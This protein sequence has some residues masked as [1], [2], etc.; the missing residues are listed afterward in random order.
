[1]LKTT[2]L[3]SSLLLKFPLDLLDIISCYTKTFRVVK[4]LQGT[5]EIV[6]SEKDE[7]IVCSRAPSA[8]ILAAKINESF[9]SFELLNTDTKWS[10]LF[11]YAIG[12]LDVD[13]ILN[14]IQESIPEPANSWRK[15][16][17]LISNRGDLVFVAD[18]IHH[19]LQWIDKQW[20]NI[21]TMKKKIY[22]CCFYT[23]CLMMVCGDGEHF[24]V[25]E[26]DL[27]SCHLKQRRS[28]PQSVQ[29]SHKYNG[30]EKKHYAFPVH[31][32]FVLI[33]VEYACVQSFH[34]TKRFGVLHYQYEENEWTPLK[35][36]LPHDVIHTLQNNDSCE[37]DGSTMKIK[38]MNRV[39][40]WH[41]QELLTPSLAEWIEI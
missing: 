1:M 33:W 35:W 10:S 18:S 21:S 11:M 5:V 20:Y 2:L 27:S 13:G 31:D 8:T 7:I 29:Q 39:F 19:C 37:Y 24:Q 38:L 25:F 3:L 12:T 6:D 16:H 34:K 23:H 9:I 15:R 36:T 32:G 40:Q 30:Y 41:T 22:A 28:T 4:L 26:Y 14:M 17:I